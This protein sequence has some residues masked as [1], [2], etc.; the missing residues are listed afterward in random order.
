M[1][2][3]KLT[4]RSAMRRSGVVVG[5]GILLALWGDPAYDLNADGAT[6][7]ADLGLLLARWGSCP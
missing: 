2:R 5:L 4:I 3:A 6:D 7:G 1:E